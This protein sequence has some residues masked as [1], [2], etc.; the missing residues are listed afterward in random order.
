MNVPKSEICTIGDQLFT[1][2]L[3]AKLFGIKI[4]S[5]PTYRA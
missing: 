4:H 1:D 2:I 5:C 3:G